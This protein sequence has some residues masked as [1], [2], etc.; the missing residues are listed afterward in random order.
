MRGLNWLA[1]LTLDWSSLQGFLSKAF[2]KM[3]LPE[4]P[5]AGGLRSRL[6]QMQPTSLLRGS[7]LMDQS[8]FQMT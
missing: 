7:K 6:W 1:K 5:K 2:P 8:S 4:V 3:A